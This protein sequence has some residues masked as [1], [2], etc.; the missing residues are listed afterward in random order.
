MKTKDFTRPDRLIL[1]GLKTLG[2]LTGRLYT[3]EKTNAKANAEVAFIGTRKLDKVSWQLYEYDLGAQQLSVDISS[4]DFIKKPRSEKNYWLNMHGIHEVTLIR[5]IGDLVGLDRLTV[6]QIVDTTQRPKVVEQNHCL[7]LSV[8]S[9]LKEKPGE[10]NVEQMSFILGPHF[11]ISFQEEVGDHFDAIRHKITEGIGFI[12]SKECDY[13][14][15]QLLDSI[16]DNYYETIDKINL[17]V[18]EIEKLLLGRSDPEDSLLLVIEGHKRSSQLLKKSLGPF[19]EALQNIMN[20][21]TDLIKR[22]NLKYFKD[23]NNSV[24]AALE[25]TDSTLRNLEGLT[26]IYFASLSQKMNEVMKVLTTVATIFIP[27]T[28]I[29]GIYGMNFEYMPELSYRFGYFI[30]WGVMFLIFIGML[31]YFK[32][33]RWL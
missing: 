24:V 22:E 16:L 4:F 13:L 9:I 18:L 1:S 10:L 25:E 28:F 27:L 2:S 7:F 31:I 14:L 33:K 5:K 30:I 12:R 29:A 19:R 3:T 32:R 17:E 23:L 20:E 11:V 6:R 26:N 8:K 21:R 15:F